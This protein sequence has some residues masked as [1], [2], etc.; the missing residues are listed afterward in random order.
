MRFCFSYFFFFVFGFSNFLF[1][2]KQVDSENLC[3][4]ENCLEYNQ[5]KVLSFRFNPKNDFLQVWPGSMGTCCYC[6][7]RC[8]KSSN[9][10]TSFK[11]VFLN[12]MLSSKMGYSEKKVFDYLCNYI[13]R[14]FDYIDDKFSGREFKDK[15]ELLCALV[16][17]L[18][19]HMQLEKKPSQG[20]IKNAMDTIFW[21]GLDM[22]EEKR[23]V[24]F[25]KKLKAP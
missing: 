17:L 9:K 25:S 6:F 24:L 16:V 12:F 15:L 3:L 2:A 8:F 21:D 7:L 22:I 14:R 19:E 1:F 23:E 10:T 18:N 20:D 11:T 13:D 4:F 5:E